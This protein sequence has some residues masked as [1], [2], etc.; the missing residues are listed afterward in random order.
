MGLAVESGD[1][2][3]SLLPHG[4]DLLELLGTS[5]QARGERFRSSQPTGEVDAPSVVAVR[6][7]ELGAE[8]GHR[9]VGLAAGDCRRAETVID[10]GR[11]HVL[12][13]PVRVDDRRELPNR[14]AGHLPLD[15]VNAKRGGRLL[16]RRSAFGIPY[17]RRRPDGLRLRVDSELLPVRS[18]GSGALEPLDPLERIRGD[19]PQ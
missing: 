11:Q 17:T 13:T 4:S 3:E 10:M 7:L 5:A 18:D 1:R 16:P 15:S 19:G 9:P 8:P 2:D 14:V 12:F 6:R